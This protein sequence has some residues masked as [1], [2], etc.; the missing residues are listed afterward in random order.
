MIQVFICDPYRALLLQ[1]Q[2]DNA[3]QRA[4][5]ELEVD[6][7]RERVLARR[8][9][10]GRGECPWPWYADAPLAIEEPEVFEV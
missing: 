1:L 10:L 5:E 9:V 2:L 3:R 4:A 7:E 8:E 6:Q